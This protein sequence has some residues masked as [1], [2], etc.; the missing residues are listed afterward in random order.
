MGFRATQ[1][2]RFKLLEMQVDLDLKGY[3]HKDEESG[4]ETGI[5]LPYI[6]TI[7]KGTTNILAI[8][9]NWEPDDELCQKRTHFVHYGYIPGLWFL[10]L[11]PCP[12]HWCFC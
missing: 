7:E 5:A 11:W 4:E 2:D 6:V 1:D 3:E 10:Q 8:R 12:P 9:R